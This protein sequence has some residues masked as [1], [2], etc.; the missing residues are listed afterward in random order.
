MKLSK[1]YLFILYSMAAINLRY[2]FLLY[3]GFFYSIWFFLYFNCTKTIFCVQWCIVIVDIANTIVLPDY[4]VVIFVFCIFDEIK[5]RILQGWLLEVTFDNKR[6]VCKYKNN[7]KW[8][9]LQK[10][11]LA[12]K[13]ALRIEYSMY[14]RLREI[15][16]IFLP[17]EFQYGYWSHMYIEFSRNKKKVPITDYKI[18]FFSTKINTKFNIVHTW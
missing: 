5:Y 9:C 8:N 3:I 15:W 6:F 17:V 11:L 2:L 1:Y 4:L 18:T 12:Q 16:Y 10:I 7:L 13:M 14:C